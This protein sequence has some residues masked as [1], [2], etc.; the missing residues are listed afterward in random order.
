[1]IMRVPSVDPPFPWASSAL[2][3][4]EEDEPLTPSRMSSK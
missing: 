1:M 4:W 3:S 2:M